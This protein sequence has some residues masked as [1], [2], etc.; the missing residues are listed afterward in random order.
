MQKDLP[1]KDKVSGVV[2]RIIRFLDKVV[3][4]RTFGRNTIHPG[5]CIQKSFS[6]R[7][8]VVKVITIFLFY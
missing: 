4:K 2:Q 5:S 3:L 6:S 7:K 8:M 1:S